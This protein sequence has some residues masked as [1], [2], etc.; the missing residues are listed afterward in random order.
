MDQVLM[1]ATSSE[2][3]RAG[4][5]QQLGQQQLG[6]L[7]AA[8]AAEQRQQQQRRQD[9]RQQRRQNRREVL[10]QKWRLERQ[11]QTATFV[12]ET[13]TSRTPRPAHSEYRYSVATGQFVF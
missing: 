7:Q 2:G 9:L 4:G 13:S 3:E 12:L 6:L 5:Q 8:A 10:S 11:Q 1:L